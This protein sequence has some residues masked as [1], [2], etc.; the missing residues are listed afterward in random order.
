[1]HW[2]YGLV[3]EG[4]PAKKGENQMIHWP[5]FSSMLKDK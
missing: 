2:K 3:Y 1:M 4:L 5:I